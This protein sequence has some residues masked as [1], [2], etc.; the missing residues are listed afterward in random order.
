MAKCAVIPHTRKRKVNAEHEECRIYDS[1]FLAD[2]GCFTTFV[3][4]LKR[5]PRSVRPDQRKRA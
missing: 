3:H 2:R 4:T 5:K 1:A